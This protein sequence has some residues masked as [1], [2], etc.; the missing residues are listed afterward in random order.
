MA[1]KLKKATAKTIIASYFSAYMAN[2]K[3]SIPDIYNARGRTEK[4][5]NKQEAL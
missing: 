5:S 2:L 1:G 4:W 3:F